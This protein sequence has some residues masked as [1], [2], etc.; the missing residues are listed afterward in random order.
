MVYS[1][2]DVVL[3]TERDQKPCADFL[4]LLSVFHHPLFSFICYFLQ[5]GGKFP[6]LPSWLTERVYL[7]K[8]FSGLGVVS[9]GGGVSLGSLPMPL[10]QRAVVEDLLFLMNGIDG[11]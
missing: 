6:K 7:S 2:D 3:Q 8:D 11:R 10:Q 1:L 4:V 9:G 5:E